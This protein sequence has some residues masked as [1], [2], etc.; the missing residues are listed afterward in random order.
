MYLHVFTDSPFIETIIAQCERISS[1]NR[2]VVFSE[3]S[4]YAKSPKIEFFKSYK[5][6]KS[7]NFQ[8]RNYDRIFI[9]Y[10][11]GNAVDLILDNPGFPEYYWFLWGADGYSLIGDKLNIY[12]PKT[13]SLAKSKRPLKQI[14]K[15][16][17][18]KMLRP[19]KEKKAEAVRQIKMC[20]TY[21]TGDFQLVQ[22][23]VGSKMQ[24]L[25]FAYL[26]TA[27]L[28]KG[29]PDVAL[30]LDFSKKLK[31]LMGNSLNPTNNHIEMIDFLN[32]L[33][34][35]KNLSVVMPASYGGSDHYKKSLLPYAKAQL[36]DIFFIEN[37]M[38]YDEY[39]NVIKE[40]DVAVFFHI[41]QQG[42]NN[43]LA[44]LWLGKILIMREE[45]TLFKVFRSWG[46][47]VMG[48]TEVRSVEDIVR[49]N[50]AKADRLKSNQKILLQHLSPAVVD[51]YYNALFK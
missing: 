50:Q 13:A 31:V 14:V 5:A 44:L 3:S 15:A 24:Q 33:P 28:F 40:I 7:T 21:V 16:W 29:D 45:S 38:P 11:G 1:Q 2:Y 51:N 27:E 48:H 32:G 20:C 22:D 17:L 42:S 23:A 18:L 37:F 35:A 4:N 26:S 30:N 12:L 8:A 9:H 39:M 6:L 46:L 49:F 47:S 41:R 34:D 19:G 10:L 43:A 25:V 36:D